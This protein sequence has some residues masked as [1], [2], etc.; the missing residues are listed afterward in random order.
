MYEHRSNPF[1]LVVVIGLLL[2]ASR[3]EAL[4]TKTYTT[5]APVVNFVLEDH[6]G[7]KY[8]NDRFL[9]KWTMILFGYTHCPDVCPFTLDNLVAVTEE[10]SQKVSPKSLPTVLFVGVDP[11]RD[12]PN[13]KEYVNHFRKDFTGATGKWSEIE[14]LVVKLGG[15]VRLYKKN[16]D[17]HAYTVRHSS[18]VYIID[19]KGQL[20]ARMNPPF[21]TTRTSE[22]L[23]NIIRQFKIKQ[24]RERG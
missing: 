19:P 2:L 15:F 1:I 24:A 23:A 16:K 20:H 14:K 7:K 5:L 4:E 6:E 21:E 13:L 8:D 11:E 10:L 3:A 22:F 12:K 9:G 17:D 18:Y